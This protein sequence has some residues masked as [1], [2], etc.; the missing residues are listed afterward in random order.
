MI[1]FFGSIRG[2]VFFLMAVGVIILTFLRIVETKD[3]VA[4]TLM[5]FTAYFSRGRDSQP[6][7]V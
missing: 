6:P 2:L 4:L 7:V 1:K 5:A 3:F